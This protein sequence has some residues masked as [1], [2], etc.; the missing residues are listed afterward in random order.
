MVR[1]L[2]GDAGVDVE[3]VRFVA[4]VEHRFSHIRQTYTVF[5]C[6]TPNLA[7]EFLVLYLVSLA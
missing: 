7:G 6:R 3:D 2:I 4:D 1:R 5:S